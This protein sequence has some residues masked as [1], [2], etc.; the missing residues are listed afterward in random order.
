MLGPICVVIAEDNS[1]LRRVAVDYLASFG[2]RA[3]EAGNE[4]EAWL[5]LIN[6]PVDVLVLDLILSSPWLM[7]PFLKRMR[8]EPHIRNIPVIVT[9]AFQVDSLHSSPEGACLVDCSILQKPYD[10]CQ[11]RRIIVQAFGKSQALLA[12]DSGQGSLQ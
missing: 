1:V 6:S 12:P 2:I 11:L 7:F 10:L 4:S 8:K 3:I 5:A 9:T